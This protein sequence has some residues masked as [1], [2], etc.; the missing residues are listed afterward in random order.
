MPVTNT[1]DNDEKTII[2]MEV[3]GRWTWDEMYAASDIGYAMLQ[4]VNH[5]V[6]PIIDF[7]QSIGMPNHAITHARNMMGRQHPNT[8]MS[9]F[10]GANPLFVSLWKVYVRVYA[11]FSREQD[12]TFAKSLDEARAMLNEMMQRKPGIEASKD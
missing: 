6:Y 2:R 8:G 10:V 9:V 12:F 4:T 5:I 1:W 11:I 7:S 3:I